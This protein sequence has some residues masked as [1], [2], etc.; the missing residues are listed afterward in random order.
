MVMARM[1]AAR[2]TLASAEREWLELPF[3]AYIADPVDGARRVLAAA[4]LA[5]PALAWST[6]CAVAWCTDEAKSWPACRDNLANCLA[7]E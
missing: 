2:A 4:G 6:T 7:I 1:N 3:E 5:V